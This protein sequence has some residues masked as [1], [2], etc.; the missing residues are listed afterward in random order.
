LTQSHQP[1]EVIVVD[2]GSTDATATVVRGYG[3]P[4]VYV[5]QENR[6]VSAARNTGFQ[7]ARGEFVALLDSDDQWLPWKLEAQVRVLRRFPDVGMIWTDMIAV[8]EQGTTLD[9]RYLRK[10]YDAH[11]LA[12]LEEVCEEAGRLEDFWS[13]APATAAGAR[14]YKGDIFSQMILGNLVHT[15]TVLLRRH[16]LR[17]VGG[18]DTT[19][20]HSGEDYEFHLRTCSFGPVALLDA[21]SI[22]YRVGAADQ[23]TAPHLGIHRARNNLTTVKRWM[24]KGRGRIRLSPDMIR[25]RLAQAHGW[26]GEAELEYGDRG[27]AR[28]HLWRSVR[29]R[30]IQRRTTLLFVFGLLPAAALRGARAVKRGLRQIASRLAR[31]RLPNGDD[32][33]AA[34]M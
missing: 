27:L 8:S 25:H 17:M 13:E 26:V 24:E 18:F 5:F 14:V 29:Y 34:R 22:L 2:D 31:P 1:V 3:P 7:R 10:F 4:V 30:P 33:S 20:V 6:G 9:D 16:R 12:R 32:E 19:L 15:S 23:L 21:S 28:R 11:E